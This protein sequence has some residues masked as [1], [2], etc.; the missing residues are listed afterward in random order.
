MS[1]GHG[2]GP[3]CCSIGAFYDN[4]AE[5]ILG[6]NP[7]STLLYLVGVGPVPDRG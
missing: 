1:F 6:L 3:G 5:Q 7:P 4:E 2:A